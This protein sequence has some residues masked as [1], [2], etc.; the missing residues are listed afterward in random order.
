HCQQLT[1]AVWAFD[2]SLASPDISCFSPSISRMTGLS[3]RSINAV[4]LQI[5]KYKLTSAL[6]PEGFASTF[7]NSAGVPLPN[8]G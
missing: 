6:L 2:H 7:K 1:W 8:C 4:F 3:I 5:H